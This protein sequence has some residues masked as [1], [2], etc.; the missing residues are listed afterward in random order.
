[1]FGEGYINAFWSL[2]PEPSSL[3]LLALGAMAM[4]RRRRA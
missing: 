4:G 2:V 1:M 3:S